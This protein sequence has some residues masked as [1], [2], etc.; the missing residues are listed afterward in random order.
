MINCITT[1]TNVDA[2]TRLVNYINTSGS[3]L[4]QSPTNFSHSLSP[5]IN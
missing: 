5:E 4:S 2:T 3:N 1:L